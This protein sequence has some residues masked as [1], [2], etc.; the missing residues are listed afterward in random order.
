MAYSKDDG[1]RHRG[2]LPIHR[3]FS[4]GR[5]GTLRARF[6]ASA[7]RPAVHVTDL[8]GDGPMEAAFMAEIAA[9]QAA[10]E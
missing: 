1:C 5:P 10:S 9:L 7:A 2:L 8:E 3:S 4:I 6:G